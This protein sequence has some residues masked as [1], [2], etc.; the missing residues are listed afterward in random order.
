MAHI[1]TLPPTC[2]FHDKTF[3]SSVK[4]CWYEWRLSGQSLI[5]L[6]L[7]ENAI[8]FHISFLQWTFSWTHSRRALMCLGSKEDFNFIFTYL[9][10]SFSEINWKTRRQEKAILRSFITVLADTTPSFHGLSPYD[11]T[12]ILPYFLGSFIYL[13]ITGRDLTRFLAILFMES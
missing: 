6:F 3:L 4:L 5:P 9:G 13:L 7:L 12:R 11:L 2:C 1:L 8:V 10:F